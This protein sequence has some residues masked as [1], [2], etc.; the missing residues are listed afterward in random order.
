[1]GTILQGKKDLEPVKYQHLH[2]T[3]KEFDELTEDY[4]L[5]V[6]ATINEEKGKTEE[7]LM[8]YVQII[9]VYHE[10]SRSL[11]EGDLHGYISCLPKFTIMFFALS[12]PSYAR[13]K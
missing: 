6:S 5:Y 2:T 1:M 8:K 9:H 3:I 13:W 12:H 7:F 4:F 10:Y 11:R